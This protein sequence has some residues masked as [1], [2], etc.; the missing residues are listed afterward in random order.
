MVL[1]LIPFISGAIGWFTNYVAIKMLFHPRQERDLFLVKL[2]GI[3]P[4]RKSMLAERLGKV[5]ARDLFT[6]EMI[7][8]KIDTP[9]N[10]CQLKKGIMQEMEDY[11]MNKLKAGNPV[12]AMFVNDKM[13]DQIMQQ[14]DKSLDEMVPRLMGQITGKVGNI[15]IE[16][17]VREKVNN[18]SD[19][20]FENLLMSVI[21]KELTFIE[22]AGAV[23]GFFIGVVQVAILTLFPA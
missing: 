12:V 2:Q 17:T 22:V 19:E 13:I 8:N 20:K 21:K 15:N 4:K 18:F 7:T 16:E 5:V 14:I 9:D 23:L 11:L 3:F 6:A 10:R 1:Y